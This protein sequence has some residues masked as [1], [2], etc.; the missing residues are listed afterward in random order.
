M[1]MDARR[2]NLLKELE[3]TAAIMTITIITTRLRGN[4]G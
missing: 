4:I 1:L 2:Q 3:E